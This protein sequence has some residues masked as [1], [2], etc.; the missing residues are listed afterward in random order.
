MLI[1]DSLGIKQYRKKILSR[2]KKRVCL[3][4]LNCRLMS[5]FMSLI[6]YATLVE[7]DLITLFSRGMNPVEDDTV[8][9]SQT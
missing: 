8:V 3:T 6:I 1:F 2:H 5:E 4:I 7:N 9:W